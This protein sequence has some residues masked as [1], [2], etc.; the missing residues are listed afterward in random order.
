MEL[1]KKFK[2]NK[3]EP[4]EIQNQSPEETQKL[5]YLQDGYETS[6]SCSGRAPNLKTSLE[7]IYETFF[8]QC[9]KDEYQQE[10]LKQPYQSELETIQIKLTNKEQEVL[11]MDEDITKSQTTVEQ[12]QQDI[13]LV[14]KQP[15]NYGIDPNHKL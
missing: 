12:L 4:S 8:N 1:L 9:K 15:E 5:N 2:L 6:K 13:F 14:K 3:K 10:K 7:T 11:K